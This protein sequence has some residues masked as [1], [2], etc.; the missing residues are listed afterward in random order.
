MRPSLFLPRFRKAWRWRNYLAVTLLAVLYQPL[1]GL[2][3]EFNITPIRLDLG[4]AAKSG[5]L[6]VKNEGNEA[7]NVQMRAFVWSQD[8]EGK[9]QYTE[10]SELIFFPK[11]MTVDAHTER[12]LRTG[13]KLPPAPQEKT[14]R[15]FIEEIP[16]PRKAA[17]G[18]QVAVTLRF[19]VPI[20]VAPLKDAAQGNIAELGLSKGILR[21]LISNTGN[22]HFLIN[23]INIRGVDKKGAPLFAKTLSGWY[24]LQGVSR[25]YTTEVPA[26]VCGAVTQINIEV[27]ADVIEPLTKQLT[28][29][30]AMCST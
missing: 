3:A 8:S 5:T 4:A 25:L 13:I 6:T 14:Y 29:D 12:I 2:T 23:E 27:K 10:T 1:Q 28:V 20:F 7:L 22:R 11:I 16:G 19:G 18:T 21:A 26:D 17:Q 30:K 15:L 24:L 9:D